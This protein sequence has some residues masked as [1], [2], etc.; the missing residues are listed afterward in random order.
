[1][2]NG[3]YTARRED[4]K[5]FSANNTMMET[6]YY[7]LPLPRR[8]R[9]KKSEIKSSRFVIRNPHRLCPSLPTGLINS[10]PEI[11]I[12]SETK[13]FRPQ[14][15]LPQE[16]GDYIRSDTAA[17]RFKLVYTSCRVELREGGKEWDSRCY[18]DFEIPSF[19]MTHPPPAAAAAASDCVVSVY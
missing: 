15:G 2:A 12:Q 4:H 3:W 8:M 6:D 16:E 10:P 1:M 18:C 13:M 5:T 9:R 19:N 17:A 11:S 14:S 7:S